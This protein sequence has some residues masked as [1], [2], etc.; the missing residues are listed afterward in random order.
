LATAVAGLAVLY[1]LTAPWLA[2]RKV[3]DAYRALGRGDTAA[4]VSAARQARDLDPLSV[5]PLWVW[6]LAEE[7]RGRVAGALRRYRSAVDLQPE[8]SDTWYSL[9]AYEFALR[10]YRAALRDLDHAYGLDPYG[11]AGLPGGLLDQARA[12]VNAGL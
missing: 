7:S 5:D 1:S 4:A 11:P 10:R 12:K 8:N 6:G 2:G 9:G 3:E